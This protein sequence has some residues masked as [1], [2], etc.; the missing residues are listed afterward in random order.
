M[1]AK[2]KLTTSALRFTNPM[3]AEGL[4]LGSEGSFPERPALS[5]RLLL[6]SKPQAG[7]VLAFQLGAV[8]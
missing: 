4:K 8:E 3:K 7:E 6:G 1:Q 5:Y 2:D